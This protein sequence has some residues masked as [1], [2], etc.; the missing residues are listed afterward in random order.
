MAVTTAAG[1]RFFTIDPSDAV[2]EHAD[3]YDETTLRARYA[4]VRDQ[5][6]WVS[7]YC[8]KTVTLPGDLTLGLTEEACLRCAVKYGPA[9]N[10][11]VE[12]AEV[13]RSRNAGRDYEIEL[14]VDETDQ[15]TTLAE[16]YIIA[17]QCRRRGV[18]LVGDSAPLHR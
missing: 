3:R 11:A 12:L 18:P 8:G 17:D 9:L 15:P 7:E 4:A 10:H 5:V 1:L 16:H 6:D 2:D 13:I 14:S